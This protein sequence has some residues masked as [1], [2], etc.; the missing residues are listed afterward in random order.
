MKNTIEL[1]IYY[2]IEET[3]EK[4]YDFEEMADVLEDRICK[5]LKCNVYVTI[6]EE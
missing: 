1:P 6:R 4:H 3:G 2:I 5:Y